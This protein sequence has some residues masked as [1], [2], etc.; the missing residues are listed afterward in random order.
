MIQL[1]LLPDVKLEYIK[2]QRARRL[3]LSVSILV[4]GVSVVILL[5]LLSAGGLQRKHMN[6]LARDIKS[7]S[8]TLQKKPQINR[9][10]TVQ[11]QLESLTQLHSGKPAA[12][13]LFAYLNQV[14]PA[15]VNINDFSI[16][17]A[18]KTISITGTSGNLAKVNTYV[19]ALKRAK[20]IAGKQNGQ[21]DQGHPAFSNVVLSSFSL[22]TDTQI[23]GEAANYTINLAYDPAIF[24]ITQDVQLAVPSETVTRQ[25]VGKPNDLFQAAPST[26]KGGQ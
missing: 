16:D 21:N 3:V 13:R 19:D 4:A 24:D 22:N 10:L 6:D 17:F 15:D 2:A 14:T 12:A 9:M 20:F 5:L 23:A 25:S 8:D 7:G 11:N 26:T 1:N 18:Q